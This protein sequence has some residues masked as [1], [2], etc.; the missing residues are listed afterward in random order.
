MNGTLMKGLA[1]FFLVVFL[2]TGGL[3]LAIVLMPTQFTAPFLAIAIVCTIAVAFS[4]DARRG[5]SEFEI[6]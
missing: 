4:L 6:R 3:A 2:I 1:T 5:N